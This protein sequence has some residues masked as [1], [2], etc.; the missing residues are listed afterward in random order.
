MRRPVASELA[1]L[2]SAINKALGV[3]SQCS[4]F[5]KDMFRGHYTSPMFAIGNQQLMAAYINA[6]QNGKVML[7]DLTFGNG[8][9][10]NG[11]LAE[12]G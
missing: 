9:V 6:T 1:V 3:P 5:L 8:Q 4:P 11:F 2:T 7:E 10:I 12:N